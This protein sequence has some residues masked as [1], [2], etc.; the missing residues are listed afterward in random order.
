MIRNKTDSL[1]K[2]L[3]LI[4]FDKGQALFAMKPKVTIGAH[5]WNSITSLM[6]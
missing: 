2:V 5:I 1:K 4:H 6:K 3:F